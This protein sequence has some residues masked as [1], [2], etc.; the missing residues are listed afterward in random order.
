MPNTSDEDTLLEFPCAFAIKAFGRQ[1]SNF[2]RLVYD[3][4]KPHVP[5]LTR[6]D[7]SSR[8]SSGGRYVSVTTSIRAQSK[9]QLDAIYQTLTDSRQVLMAL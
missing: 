7:L 1:D 9:S 3:L 4:I 8:E 2:E 6:A 5:E